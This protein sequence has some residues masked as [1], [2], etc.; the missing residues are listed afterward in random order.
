MIL[1]AVEFCLSEVVSRQMIM[2]RGCHAAASVRYEVDS[3][4]SAQ[5]WSAFVAAAVPQTTPYRHH[6]GDGRKE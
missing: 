4:S 5:G 6:D 3:A 2:S 1:S